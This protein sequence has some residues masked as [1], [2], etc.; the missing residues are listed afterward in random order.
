MKSILL[1][2]Y[3]A[4]GDV[5]LAT[6]VVAPLRTKYPGVRIEWLTDRPFAGLLDGVVDR[7]IT[8]S[9]KDKSTRAAALAEV[10]GRFDLAIDL[11]NKV[12]SMRVA[13]AAAPK[14]LRFVRRTPL[15][16][17]ASLFGSD[18]VLDGAHQTLLY[19]RAAELSSPGPLHVANAESKRAAELLPDD[20]KWVAVAP[21]AAWETKRWP[22]ERL[23]RVASALCAD[24]YKIALVGGPMD[25]ALLDTLRPHADV[26]LS[27]ESL[28]VLASC[29]A[30]AQ[31]LIGNDSGLVHV[32]SAQGTPTVALFGPTSV[33]RWSPRDPGVAV[34]L[35][36][37][38][39]P[40]SN[41]GTHVCP[42]GH[43]D[44]MQ[45]LGVDQVLS[46]ARDRLSRGRSS[47]D[48]R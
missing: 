3:S 12:W 45:K 38:C 7:V 13:R 21:G 5:V 9:R 16:A 44:C 27:G 33:N 11:Q 18:V 35:G 6:S 36:L 10:K 4:L 15:Q 14:R 1:I 47:P 32:A 8:F 23:A 2:R 31:L 22:A 37:G 25:G 26:D 19:A 39:S 17:L 40:C 30:R 42:L 24:G 34:S 43:H 29:L 41:H 46:A 20:A 48:R 28:A